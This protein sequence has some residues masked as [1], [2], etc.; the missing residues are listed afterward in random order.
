MKKGKFVFYDTGMTMKNTKTSGVFKK[1]QAQVKAMNVEGESECELLVIPRPECGRIS[2]FFKYLFADIFR[3]YYDE[4]K[5]CDFIYFRRFIPTS[6]GVLKLLKRLRENS[7]VKLLYEIPTFPYD[8][9]HK[10]GVMK[11]L[12][13]IDKLFRN[14]L[15][16]YLDYTV[17]VGDGKDPF[18]TVGMNISNGIDC[19]SIKVAKPRENLDEYHFI[20]VGN[21]VNYHGCERL[22]KGMHEYYTK[23]P[24]AK[25]VIFK[26][27]GPKTAEVFKYEKLVQQFGLSETVHINGPAYGEEL[28][29]LYDWA[30][31]GISS[32]ATTNFEVLSNLKTR[33]YMARGVPFMSSSHV[34]VA[35]DDDFVYYVPNDASPVDVFATVKYLDDL[36][37][38]YDVEDLSK[39]IRTAAEERCDMKITMKPV[40]D[41]I[42]G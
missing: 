40:V 28:D 30:D 33:E 22:I 13:I 11:V 17:V 4:L 27:V 37:A 12:L 24:D 42:I 2:L 32:L 41:Y 3:D 8:Q 7:D 25:K 6:A 34:D 1:I 35:L 20:A 19:S 38:K 21:F 26:I 31:F 10:H 23:Q 36:F 9:E 5:D 16:K 29:K 39:T 18:G 15:R 14:K